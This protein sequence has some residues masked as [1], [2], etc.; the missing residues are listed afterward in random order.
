MNHVLW[1]SWGVFITPWTII[2]YIGTFLFTVRWLV[3]AVASRNAGKP[4]VPRL[5]WY[6]SIVGSAMLLGYFIWGKNDGPGI[7]SNLFPGLLAVYN[8]FL[9]ITHKKDDSALT[10]TDKIPLEVADDRPVL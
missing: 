8:L 1:N 10:G 4:T 7:V 6:M 9:D 3:Q 5:F 2:A